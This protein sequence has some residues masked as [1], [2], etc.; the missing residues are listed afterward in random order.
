M[1]FPLWKKWL[2]SHLYFLIKLNSWIDDFIQEQTNQATDAFLVFTIEN[3][4]FHS[5]GIL[6]TKT[7]LDEFVKK[8]KGVILF[9]GNMIDMYA[10]VVSNHIRRKDE[11]EKDRIATTSEADGIQLDPT[12]SVHNV[13]SGEGQKLSEDG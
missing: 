13:G 4:K 1:K 8:I 11:Q 5:Y 12:A 3:G 6:G 7:D 10:Q 2:R 9:K